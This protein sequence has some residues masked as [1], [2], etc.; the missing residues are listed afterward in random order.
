MD[1]RFPPFH[2]Q[3][4]TAWI[5]LLAQEALLLHQPILRLRRLGYGRRLTLQL[6]QEYRGR[7]L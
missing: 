7:P 1:W 4:P 3:L 6:V 2:V 5:A